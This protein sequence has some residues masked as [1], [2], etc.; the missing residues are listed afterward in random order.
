MET[1]LKENNLLNK[2]QSVFNVDK[3][4]IPLINKSG[5]FVGKK[6]T[7]DVHIPTPRER[8]GKCNSDGMLQC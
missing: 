1:I 6:R 5:K 7:K 3:S 4:G 2:L 8:E